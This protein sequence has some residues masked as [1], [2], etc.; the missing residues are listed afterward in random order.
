MW[1]DRYQQIGKTFE[2]AT[3]SIQPI[4][5]TIEPEN[6]KTILATDFDSFEL[7][8]RR[9]TLMGPIVGPGIFSNDGAAWKHSRALIRPNFTKMMISDLSTFETH[10]QNLLKA[11]PAADPHSGLIQ[12]DLMPLFFRMTLDSASETLLGSSMAFNSQL[13]LPGSASMRFMD[14]FDY[15]QKKIHLRNVL[16]RGWMKPFGLVYTLAKGS[17]KDQFEQACEVV[18][19]IIDPMILEFLRRP[20]TKKD[21]HSKYVFLEEMAKVTRD[22]LELRYEILNVLMAGRDTTAALLTNTFFVLARRPDLW[23]RVRAE[24]EET[25][26]GRLPEYE[27]MRNMKQVKNLLSECLRFYPPVPF[28]ART[29][30][31]NTTLPRGGGPDGKSPLFI[32]KG[33]QVDYHV[34]C[35]HRSP[36]VFG[37]DAHLFRPERWEDPVLRP[38]WGYIPFNGGARICLGQQFALTEASYVLVR[39][40]QEFERMDNRDPVEAWREQ[41][42]LVTKTRN[43]TSVALKRAGS[44]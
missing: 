20:V 44:R 1:I 9:R 36:D 5:F 3:V 16:D 15:V 37:E 35:L 39:L 31:A 24:V 22:P 25:F 23:D 11:L 14:A 32:K 42:G 2:S 7:G 43:G 26:H 28:N 34:Y 17:K 6:I 19:S 33:Q 30:K 40:M 29:A 38:G 21:P 10:F 13:D 4:I 8:S 18:H 27:T 41:I 12:V